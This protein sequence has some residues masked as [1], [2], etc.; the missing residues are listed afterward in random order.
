MSNWSMADRVP[1]DGCTQP[2]NLAY[3]EFHRLAVHD[4]TAAGAVAQVVQE[5]RTTPG[6]RHPGLDPVS[7]ELTYA[8]DRLLRGPGGVEQRLQA[9][10][11]ELRTNSEELHASARSYRQADE[12]AEA[13][14]RHLGGL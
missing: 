13:G 12:Q 10:S 9:I 4:H 3:A 8:L 1:G 5:I 7:L 14:L 2:S 11:D 6:P